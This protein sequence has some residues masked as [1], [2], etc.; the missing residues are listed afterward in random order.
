MAASSWQTQITPYED[1]LEFFCAAFIEAYIIRANDKL[2]LGDL[3]MS[4]R[5]WRVVV[6]E[7]KQTFVYL[8][9]RPGYH[10]SSAINWSVYFPYEIPLLAE[11]DDID[12]VAQLMGLREIIDAVPYPFIPIPEGVNF[13]EIGTWATE[14][15]TRLADEH[16]AYTYPTFEEA[17]LRMTQN[18]GMLFELEQTMRAFV[19]QHLEAAFGTN[20]WDRA[21]IDTDIRNTVA[22]R[23]TEPTN[24]WLDDYS[25]SVLRFTDLDHLRLIILKNYSVFKDK[26]ADRDWFNSTMIYLTRPRNRVGHVNTFSAD[27]SQEFI[28]TANR[29]LKVLRPHVQLA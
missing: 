5:N 21:N 29:I 6:A 2:F 20:W 23:Q 8:E 4:V 24:Q 1:M 13:E 9:Y 10:V 3:P 15:A 27:D 12:A 14:W 16:I 7:A 18:Y 11:A 25:T 22:R 26:I 28:F 17:K 19:A